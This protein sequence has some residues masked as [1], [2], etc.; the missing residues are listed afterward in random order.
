MKFLQKFCFSPFLLTLYF[1]VSLWV[2]NYGE[3][4]FFSI[5]RALF[6]VLV[7]V[8]VVF[9]VT[10]VLTRDCIKAAVITDIFTLLFFTYGHV[11]NVVQANYGLETGRHRYLL[12]AAAILFAI[13]VFFVLRA[14]KRIKGINL[15]INLVTFSLFMMIFV[16]TVVKVTPPLKTIKANSLASAGASELLDISTSGNDGDVY[17]IVLDSYG[18]QDLL[19]SKYNI[20]TSEFIQQ[21]ISRGFVVPECTLSNYDKTPYS[22]ASTLNMTYL[23]DFGIST[24][25]AIKV[26]DSEFQPLIQY[27]E[28]REKFESLGY[29][30]VTFKSVYPYIDISDSDIYYDLEKDKPFFNK[31]ESINF[32]YLFYD[33][34][35][36]HP[37]IGLQKSRPTRFDFI[38]DP[39]IRIFNPKADLF[40]SREYKVFE[41]SQYALRKLNELPDNPGRKFVY[42]HLF[43]THDPFVFQTDGTFRDNF[44]YDS[45]AAQRDQYN[46][47]NEQI[48]RIIDGIIKNSEQPPII[49]LQG[50]HA[51]NRVKPEDKTKILNAY[52]L[53]GGGNDLVYPTITPVN[54]FRLILSY[55]FGED[56]PFLPDRSYYREVGDEIILFDA[57]PSCIK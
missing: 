31:A 16:Q 6:Q 49:I 45:E 46:Y 20:D 33:T 1:I 34:T 11:Y 19:Q 28:V 54:T 24:S 35:M 13:G 7:V 30:L 2:V 14:R 56:L 9:M 48:L 39:I 52:Y 29:Q 3:T 4:P 40:L 12:V 57:E 51:Y 42:A 43:I 47:S 41:Q 27:S 18:R 8:V 10:R 38:L 53:P 5:F 44:D 17:Y 36:M 23:V 32:L 26:N 50:D 15:W 25:G 55:Y 22:I 21:L 37:L